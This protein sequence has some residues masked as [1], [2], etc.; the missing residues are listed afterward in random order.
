MRIPEWVKGIVILGLVVVSAC[1][2]GLILTGI[3]YKLT[4]AEPR[5]I[6]R[7]GFGSGTD[8]T[9][10]KLKWLRCEEL[11]RACCPCLPE[12]PLEG[13]KEASP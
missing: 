1:Y 13:L 7:G 3:A 9:K 8:L 12:R 5:M 2:I 4:S 11:E 6:Q 10:R